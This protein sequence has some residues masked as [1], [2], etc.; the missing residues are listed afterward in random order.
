ML[1]SLYNS[2][3]LA[4][5]ECRAAHGEGRSP[6]T[7]E[8]EKSPRSA[9]GQERDW[10]LA[11]GWG[12]RPG[13]PMAPCPLSSHSS[14]Q[15]WKSWRKMSGWSTSGDGVWSWKTPEKGEEK[16]KPCRHGQEHPAPASSGMAADGTCNKKETMHLSLQPSCKQPSISARLK[17]WSIL[18]DR[19]Q[20]FLL[21]THNKCL[22]IRI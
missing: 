7:S 13:G 1:W 4:V 3:S 21:R 15:C 14:T 19:H 16:C 12:G 20:V 6:N 10:A 2:L 5:C 8:K 22:S 11:V 17:R 18:K 9:V